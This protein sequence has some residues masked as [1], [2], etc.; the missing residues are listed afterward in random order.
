MGTRFC[1]QKPLAVF[2]CLLLRNWGWLVCVVSKLAPTLAKSDAHASRT[3]HS[4]ALNQEK[5]PFSFVLNNATGLHADTPA[6]KSPFHMKYKVIQSSKFSDLG[7]KKILTFKTFFKRI[8][9]MN[10]NLGS[11]T[12]EVE[13]GRGCLEGSSYDHSHIVKSCCSLNTS[14]LRRV[15]PGSNIS[16]T[17]TWTGPAPYPGSCF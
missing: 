6:L 3:E 8:L 7:G 2:K 11:H 4:V 10:L 13:G 14:R 5:A 9:H 16:S 12:Q 15:R 17:K 1:K